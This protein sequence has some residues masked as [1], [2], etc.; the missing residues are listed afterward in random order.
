M[1]RSYVLVALVLLPA[2]A[3]AQASTTPTTTAAPGSCTGGLTA[4]ISFAA[5]TAADKAKDSSSRTSISASYAARVFGKAECQC[6]PQEDSLDAIYMRLQ[7]SSGLSSGA[8][9]NVTAWVGTGCDD[10]LTRIN[11]SAVSCRQFQPMNLTPSSFNAGS[12]N[13]G[14]SVFYDL[15]VPA[16]ELFSPAT[17]SCDTDGTNQIWIF[18]GLTQ[19]MPD[20]T[21]T[22]PISERSTGASKPV[23]PRAT[24]GDSAVNV[25][26]DVPTISN[27]PT[28]RQ[29]TYFQILCSDDAGNPVKP[30]PQQA[31][32]STC[33]ASGIERRQNIFGASNIGSSTG[34]GGTTTTDD[35]GTL[36]AGVPS[37]AFPAV[38]DGGVADAGVDAGANP[39]MTVLDPLDTTIRPSVFESL[40]GYPYLAT[41]DPKYVCTAGTQP[42]GTTQ[43]N[44]ID[45]LV[46]NQIYHFVIVSIDDYGNPTPSDV[47]TAQPQPAEDLYGAL[48]QAGSKAHGFCFVAT[49]A[50]GNYDHPQVRLL[51]EFRD[52]V[53]A[54]SAFGRAFVR[55]YY[56]HSP[57]LAAWI[58][59]SDGRR[60]VARGLLWPLVVLASLAL[61]LHSL[62]LAL[63]LVVA[64]PFAAVRLRRRLRRRSA[65]FVEVTA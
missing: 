65:P 49:A 56:R 13:I 17:G 32:Y 31:Y 26:F 33:L 9:T 18:E 62:V 4:T 58:A 15:W 11:K 6:A 64:L 20:A 59:R 30:N 34:D 16:R 36:S 44:R 35:A 19:Q 60:L 5:R 51:R 42:T 2:V 47:L 10:Y 3:F 53:L 57:P 23:S 52:N 24:S 22:V 28:L 45:G 43:T 54:A 37:G 38:T 48:Q 27:T 29:A 50:Y 41:L 8:I 39:D 12:G 1:L 46:N 63:F 40:A 61:A 25:T 14:N 21:C 7:V 55:G